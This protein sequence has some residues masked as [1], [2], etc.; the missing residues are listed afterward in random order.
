[1]L[2]VK[3][4]DEA[5]ESRYGGRRW[6]KMEVSLGPMREDARMTD[7]AVNNRTA[8]NPRRR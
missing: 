1:M 2:V 4:S 7:T 5:C 6:V 3:P 8:R